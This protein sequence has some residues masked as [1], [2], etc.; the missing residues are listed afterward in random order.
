MK[1][2]KNKGIT[3]IALIITIIVLLL[4]A[5]ISVNM[6][7]GQDGILT[8]ANEAKNAQQEA[9]RREKEVID[10]MEFLLGSQEAPWSEEEAEVFAGGDGTQE[11]PYRVENA[12]QLLYFAEQVN[13]GETYTGQYIS[14]ESDIDLKYKEW[15]PIGFGVEDPNEGYSTY[16]DGNFNG[17]GHKIK[18]INIQRENM[19]GVGLFSVITENGLVE[20]L[21]VTSGRVI[22]KLF[23]GGIAG[24]TA[25]NIKNCISDLE[26]IA[27]DNSKGWSGEFAGGISGSIVFGSIENCTNY[28]DVITKNDYK[29]TQ[30]GKRAGGIAGGAEQGASIKNCTNY[31]HVTS[32]YQ[33]AGGIVASNYNSTIEGCTN[34][35]NVLAKYQEELANSGLLCGG[36][37]G[38]IMQTEEEVSSVEVKNCMNTGEV[39]A[40]VQRAGG[41][42]G[43]QDEGTIE[44]CKNTGTVISKYNETTSNTGW[45]AGGIVSLQ[46]GGI[47]KECVN[48]G[49]I[50]AEVNMA[51]GITGRS[52]GK[53]NYC[54]NE[55][56]VKQLSKE[57]SD[58]SFSYKSGG[59]S[60]DNN[61]GTIE[62]CYNIGSIQTEKATGTIDEIGGIVGLNRTS[63]TIKYCYNRGMVTGGDAIGGVLG[64]LYDGTLEKNYYYVSNINT[65]IGH[66]GTSYTEVTPGSDITGQAEKI[67]EAEAKNITSFDKFKQWISTK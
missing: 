6:I 59:I 36:I 23:V 37:I 45:F 14:L 40:E 67:S 33:I 26:I 4:L 42:I 2:E 46:E 50:I 56:K 20:N 57:E 7:S 10:E 61:G 63:G 24:E 43:E 52:V 11:N 25:G 58:G 9:E 47:V 28:G 5:G 22:G 60:G 30:R 18:N 39:V 64:Q 66:N 21:E 48:S 17:N 8:K 35:G 29:K 15:I 3:L 54:W 41:I 32:M 53:V 55:G 51:G 1:K 65:A 27:Q 34:N 16:F 31:G 62:Y 12:K 19:T 49:E 13:N 38:W 44:L